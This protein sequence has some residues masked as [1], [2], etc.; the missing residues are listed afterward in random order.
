MI[1][2]GC[3]P[4]PSNWDSLTDLGS[5]LGHGI[6]T[7]CTGNFA[8]NPVCPMRSRLPALVDGLWQTPTSC[9][10]KPKVVVLWV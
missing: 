7:L 8:R 5:A 1:A 9:Q 10:E 4:G 6:V 2:G 3:P